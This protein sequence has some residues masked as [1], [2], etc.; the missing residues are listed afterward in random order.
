MLWQ[1]ANE[2]LRAA[3]QPVPVLSAVRSVSLPLTS[4]LPLASFP[5]ATGQQQGVSGRC[6]AHAAGPQGGRGNP[7]RPAGS[8]RRQWPRCAIEL[9]RAGGADKAYLLAAAEWHKLIGYV[10]PCSFAA[11]SRGHALPLHQLRHR[12]AALCVCSGAWSWHWRY[13]RAATHCRP[14]LHTAACRLPGPQCLTALGCGGSD[15]ASG[16]RA[17]RSGALPPDGCRQPCH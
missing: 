12:A 9:G 15:G 4:T 16:S 8:R 17:G 6:G 11:C 1:M 14:A 10:F 3:P 2:M 7:A 5:P 13:G